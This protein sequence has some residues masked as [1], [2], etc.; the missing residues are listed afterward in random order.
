MPLLPF[1][2]NVKQIKKSLKEA[3]DLPCEA[4]A[5]IKQVE[6]MEERGKRLGLWHL[7]TLTSMANL[8]CTY[9]YQGRWDE[10]EKLEVEVIEANKAKLGSQHQDTLTSMAD[11]ASRNQV[12]WDEAEKLQ[13]EVIAVSKE[14][15][16]ERL[17]NILHNIS[18]H[19]TYISVY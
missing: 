2:L 16:V 11:L 8:A 5:H 7:D 3:S 6:V 17:S 1:I 4:V 9:R 10:A 14:K 13:I 15:L 12:R 19:S 18:N